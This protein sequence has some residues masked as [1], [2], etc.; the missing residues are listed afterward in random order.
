MSEF[1]SSRLSATKTTVRR[2]IVPRS[3]IEQTVRE[4]RARSSGWRESAA[5]WSGTRDGL[6]EQVFFHHRLGNDRGGPLSLELPEHAKLGLYQKLAAQNQVLLAL[7]HT[8]PEGW[9][10]LSKIDQQ[11]QLS[12]RVGFWSIVL[13]YYGRNDWNP[14][15]IGFHIRVEHGWLQ[16]SLDEVEQ[17]FSIV[18]A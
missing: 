5:I 3:I 7:L 13:P 14:R 6:V 8:H 15:D 4:L 2:C 12:S 18:D 9:V 17:H 11:N 16:L 1:A 10:G